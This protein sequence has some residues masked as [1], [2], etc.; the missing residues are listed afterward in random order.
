MKYTE[1]LNAGHYVSHDQPKVFGNLLNTWL[2]TL[3]QEKS[4]HITSEQE[5][6][7]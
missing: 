4:N 3:S 6:S 1:L 2:K 5:L 7:E